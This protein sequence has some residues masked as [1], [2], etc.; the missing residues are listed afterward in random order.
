MRI[1]FLMVRHPKTRTSP[2]MPEVHRLLTEWGV[3]VDVLYPDEGATDL[4][5]VRV[6]HDLYV[7]KS[8]TE[9]A[10]SLAGT[11]DALGAN[12]IN[13]FPVAAACRDKVVA[14]KILQR[15]GVPVPETYLAAT[16]A[17][18]EPLLEAGPLVVKPHRG[19]QGRGV[20]VVWDTD[21]LD[22]V[23]APDGLSFAQRY[24]EPQGR[25]RKLYCIGGQVFG[26]KRVWP[27]RSY[28]DKLGE[29]FTVTPE[30]RA[31]AR[32]CGEAFGMD[33]YGLDI[34]ISDGR[35]FVVDISSFPGFKGVPDAAL[36][37]AD[38]IYAAGQRVMVGAAAVPSY[39]ER[40]SA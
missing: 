16:P 9:V 32:R 39:A 11:L 34:V 21:E 4:G 24:Y 40:I 15:A 8:G 28:E 3:A 38:Y 31:I 14:T 22:A 2:V 27:V 7:L 1:A 13:P 23:S 35:P 12:I 18:L 17:A 25:D 6:E 10:L 37:L 5:T 26:V 29:P 20:R 36:R 30:L 19:S 33:V